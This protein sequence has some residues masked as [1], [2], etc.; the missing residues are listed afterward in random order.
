MDEYCNPFP[1]IGLRRVW[2][3]VYIENRVRSIDCK[4]NWEKLGKLVSSNI[5]NMR[6]FPGIYAFVVCHP[7]SKQLPIKLSEV[8]YIG[9]SLDIKKRFSDY[10]SDKKEVDKKSRLNISV[11]DNIRIMFEEYGSELEVFYA[12]APPDRIANIEDIYIQ[13]LDPILNSGQKLD[14][15]KF[16]NFETELKAMFNNVEDAF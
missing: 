7:N 14:E 15:E 6:S 10:I 12:K 16:V 13:I 3:K 5:K 8:I 11:R 4:V 2:S 1:P 9:K